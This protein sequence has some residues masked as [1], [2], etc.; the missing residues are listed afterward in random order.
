MAVLIINLLSV[1]NQKLKFNTMKN[2]FYFNLHYFY[3]NGKRK[4]IRF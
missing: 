3:N 1:N 2:C 4:Y